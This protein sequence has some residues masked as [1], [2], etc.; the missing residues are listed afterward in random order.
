MQPRQHVRAVPHRV[1]GVQLDGLGQATRT[2][3]CEGI[4]EPT[5][6]SVV[7]C[8]AQLAKTKLKEN[9]ARAEGA[10]SSNEDGGVIGSRV[11]E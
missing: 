5:N 8:V 7:S 11:R 3:A 1:V 6:N 10:K 2:T 9:S 4:D